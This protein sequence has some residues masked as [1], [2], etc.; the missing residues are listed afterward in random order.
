MSPRRRSRIR[1]RSAAFVLTAVVSLIATSSRANFHIAEIDELMVGY[2]NNAAVQFVEIVMKSGGQ[3]V[4]NGSKLATFD[5]TGAFTGIALTV[6][7][8]VTSGSDRR[9][10]MATPGFQSASGLDADFLFASALPTG[11]G[12]ICWG[13]PG[14]QES[15][16]NA[17]VDCVAYGNYT[18][19]G[20]THTSAPTTLV[21]FGY[22]LRRTGDSDS[23][24]NDFA[25]A[26]PADPEN[27]DFETVDLQAT[28]PCPSGSTTTTTAPP[29]TNTST[30]TTT[31]GGGAVCGDG[32]VDGNVTAT[33]ALFALNTSVGAGACQ[34]CRCDV[35][36]TGSVTAT[37]A[38]RI[39]NA[40]VGVPV[41]LN[42]VAC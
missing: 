19:P 16:P 21:P 29:T 34:A 30:T 1:R 28:T 8:N 20:N 22:S 26:D 39:L 6:S 32:N 9:W 37:D 42:C 12:M 15:S 38:L 31:L 27:N 25:C 2:D 11:G 5:A 23:T 41:S 17:Y 10:L 14:A 18:G 13:K 40:A 33:D 36:A 3:G 24:L 7:S 35:D 4:V